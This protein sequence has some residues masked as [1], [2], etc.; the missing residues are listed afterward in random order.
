MLKKVFDKRDES[1]AV[2]IK[3]AVFPVPFQNGLEYNPPAR[4]VWNIVHTGMLIP[5]A[6]QIFACPRGCLR[7]VILTASEMNESGRM[8]W[9]GVSEDDFTNG[10]LEQNIIDATQE[11]LESCEKLPP[12]VLIFISCIHLFS[13]TDFEMILTELSEKF[14][15]VDFVDCYM[16]PTMRKTI[17]PDAKMRISLYKPLKK[18]PEN[19]KSIN[20]IG[21]DFRTDRESELIEILETNGYEIKEL[22]ACRNYHEYL[23]M[24]ESFLNLTLI[25]NAFQS[26]HILS[27]R[28]K[29]VHIHIPCCYGYDE[30]EENY[31]RLFSFLKTEM[32]DF[33]NERIRC[34]NALAN[35]LKVIGKTAVSI[36]YTAVFRPL[37]LARLLAQH[38]FNVTEIICDVFSQE[39]KEDFEFL[40]HN[41][42]DIEIRCS[43]KPEMRFYHNESCE[44]ILCIGQKSA[45]YNS[46]DYFVNIV[47]GGGFYGFRGIEKICSL[48]TEAFLVPKDRRKEISRKGLG[49]ESCL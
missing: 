45:W 20:I 10:K 6:R 15:S 46:S 30:I 37:G 18:L 35:A 29:T 7:G 2:K 40:Q 31:R 3:D 47:S 49:C 23:E 11:I 9:I 1:T 12:C 27:Q 16:T 33:E 32:P 17:S 36:D 8:S 39:E 4:G 44:K 41:F 13:G 5:E 28:L 26:G 19:K 21:S 42:P 25:P 48:M 43:V 34:E 14:P 22:P 38:G 24:G